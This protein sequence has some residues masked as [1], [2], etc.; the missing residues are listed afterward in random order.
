MFSSD[1]GFHMNGMKGSG[2]YAHGSYSLYAWMHC[3]LVGEANVGYRWYV[4]G[5]EK[6]SMSFSGTLAYTGGE[7]SIG[8]GMREDVIEPANAYFSIVRIYNKALSASEISYNFENERN[9]FGI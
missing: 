4:N 2:N 7:Q 5:V 6:D 8:I 9:K 3:V 1:G